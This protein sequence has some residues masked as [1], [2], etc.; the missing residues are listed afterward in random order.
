MTTYALGQRS[1]ARLD[2]VHPVLITVGKRAIVISTQDFG[3]Y[4]GVRTLERQR[5]LVASGASKRYC[6][7]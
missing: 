7:T 6:Q 2:G 3:V 5:K 1:L 4:E